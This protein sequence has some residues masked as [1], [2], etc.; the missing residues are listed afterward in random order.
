MLDLE[1]F[2]IGGGL[3]HAW[4]SRRF[5]SPVK[6]MET[7]QPH[8]GLGLAAYVQWT[9]PIRRFSDMLVHIS[10]KR[11]LRRERVY[12]L[13]KNGMDIPEG[14]RDQDLGFPPGLV[15]DGKLTASSVS[16][17]EIDEDINFLEGSGLVGAA[18]TLQRQSQQYWMFEYICRL[19]NND[20][21]IT[22]SAVVLGCVDSERRQYAVYIERLGL[23]HR[24]TCPAGTLEPGTRIRLKVDNVSPRFCSL[25]FVRAV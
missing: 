13:L 6:V 14:I 19:R 18:R 17:V 8:S 15:K 23:E 9:S 1:E 16:S 20:A 24:Y 25:G 11:H 12:E 22:F 4:Y 2:N 3:C 7:Q 10:V 21:D 5:M